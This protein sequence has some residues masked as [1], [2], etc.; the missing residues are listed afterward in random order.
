MNKWNSPFCL[1]ALGLY[2]IPEYDYSQS[3][4]ESMKRDRSMNGRFYLEC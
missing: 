1:T 4:W 2:H 3:G